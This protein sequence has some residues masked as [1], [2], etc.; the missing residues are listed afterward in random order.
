MKNIFLPLLLIIGLSMSMNS[1]SMLNWE[2]NYEKAVKKA[3]KEKKPVLLFF[4]GSDWCGP[5]KMLKADFFKTKRFKKIADDNFVLYEADF[6]KKSRTLS[7][8][9]RKKNY[10]LG[11]MYDVNSYPTIVIIDANGKEIARK[12]S[13]NLMRD[14]SYHFRFLK[15]VLGK[16]NI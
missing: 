2:D 9:K 3:K 14:P 4:T 13:Y 7:E 10:W 15:D 1:Q 16:Q 12:K 6:P 5:C 8:E 11:G